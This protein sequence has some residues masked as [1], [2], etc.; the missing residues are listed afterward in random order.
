M[1]P[2]ADWSQPGPAKPD[3]SAIVEKPW[4]CEELLVDGEYALKRLTVQPGQTLS[5]QYHRDKTETMVC[6][7]GVGRISLGRELGVVSPSSVFWLRPGV[8]VHVPA[9]IV[10]RVWSVGNHP[11]II[12]EAATSA[13]PADIVRLEDT[14][15]RK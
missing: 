8:T 12:I 15:G 7:Q 5:L 13:D 9:G 10:H 11:L 6:V 4:G 14:Y 2:Q 1:K 3:P